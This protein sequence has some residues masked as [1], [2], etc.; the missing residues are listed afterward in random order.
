[1]AIADKQPNVPCHAVVGFSVATSR[2][3]LELETT[4]KPHACLFLQKHVVTC[5]IHISSVQLART[6]HTH[7]DY[8]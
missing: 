7:D 8:T 3:K 2:L 6:A 4:T 1:M 5:N